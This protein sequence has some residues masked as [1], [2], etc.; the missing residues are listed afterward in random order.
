MISVQIF[1]KF[2]HVLGKI[3]RA[4]PS[5]Q[6]YFSQVDIKPGLIVVEML[7]LKKKSC[8]NWTLEEV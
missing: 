8:L 6:Y 3:D 2:W 7:F 1:L 5:E 4:E